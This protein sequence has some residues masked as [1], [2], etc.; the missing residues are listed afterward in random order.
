[1][2]PEP[3]DDVRRQEYVDRLVQSSA[4]LKI[5]VAGPGTGKSFAFRRV[6]ESLPDGDRV[7]LS[8][9]N[10]LVHDLQKD[11][12][13]LAESKT[14][15]AYCRGLL[16]RRASD[17]LTTEFHYFPPLEQLVATDAT[18]L[19][20]SDLPSRNFSEALHTLEE[21]DGRIA[22]FLERSSYYNAVGFDDSVYRVLKTF[23]ADATRVPALSYLIVDEFQDFNQLEVSFL[24]HLERTTPTLIAGDDDQA[25]YQSLRH[26]KPD[27][28][29]D[30]HRGGAHERFELPYCSRCPR[31][32]V[33]ATNAFVQRAQ[34]HGLLADRIPKQ[35]LP[36]SGK[37]A[38]SAA[39]PMI[40]N[41]KCSAD[42]VASPQIAAYIAHEI[43]AI[44]QDIRDEAGNPDTGY[45]LALILGPGQYLKRI[46]DVLKDRIPNLRYKERRDLAFDHLDGYRALLKHP[47]G[48]LGWR[49]LLECC[50]HRQLKKFLKKAHDGGTSLH[51][52]LPAT[53]IAEHTALLDTLRRAI[54][55]ENAVSDQEWQTLE[56]TLGF[57]KDTILARLKAEDAR[58]KDGAHPERNGSV[59]LTSYSGAKGLSAAK[60]FVVGMEQGALPKNNQQ[61]TDEE[62]NQFVVALTRARKQ[63]HLIHTG[64]F[65]GQRQMRSVFVDWL[66][67]GLLEGRL[68]NADLLHRWERESSTS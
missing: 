8:F 24:L 58:D 51:E 67:A 35:F 42:T 3:N 53:F 20:R 27:F 18:L 11:L 13:G 22:F 16:H 66:P 63:C 36:F 4:R 55:D 17:G 14:F 26:A 21:G 30:K 10:N 41:V 23:D 31:V 49:I 32:L 1:M 5:V 9:I 60:V 65:M 2:T 54:A 6:L 56:A 29:R 50:N 64:Q 25:I 48:N 19:G 28:I 61:P 34:A 12:A 45:P 37:D 38:D 46:N 40:V 33:E 39:F 62:I 68:V 15:H 47:E 57:P 52:A 43:E 59:I 7:A 44:G